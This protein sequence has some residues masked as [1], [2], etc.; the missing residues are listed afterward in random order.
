MGIMLRIMQVKNQM[1]N[2][3]VP[4]FVVEALPCRADPLDQ[5][6]HTR[7]STLRQVL[8][9]LVPDPSK[10]LSVFSD[11]QRLEGRFCSTALP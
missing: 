10:L 7:H 4:R 2:S 3:D 8:L 1:N 9:G 5:V 11:G 6:A